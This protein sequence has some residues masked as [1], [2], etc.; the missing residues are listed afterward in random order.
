MKFCGEDIISVIV[1]VYN[2]EKYLKECVDSIRNQSYVNLEIILVDD[3]STD[4]SSELCDMFAEEDARIKVLH[5]KN[6]GLV[7]ARQE[8][9]K[10]ATGEYIVFVD[11]DDWI[12][13]DM[14]EKLYLL[15]R[16]YSTD[17]VISGII[18]EK[19]EGQKYDSN[20]LC[21]GYYDKEML[22]SNVYPH[23]MFDLEKRSYYIDPSLCNKL[24]RASLIKNCILM[25]DK[26]IFYLGEDAAVI[27]PCLLKADNIL[28]TKLCMYHHRIVPQE[29]VADY[30][31]EKI[32]ERLLILYKYLQSTYENMGMGDIMLPQ[33][34]GY[35]THMLGRTTY[36]AINFDFFTFLENY[37]IENS[38]VNPTAIN[39]FR[40]KF[41]FGQLQGY[42]R[43]I[44]YGAGKVGIEYYGQLKNNKYNVIL[45]VDKRGDDIAR[46]SGLPIKNIDNIK[47]KEFDIIILATK[48]KD[49][50]QEMRKDIESIGIESSKIRW[51]QPIE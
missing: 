44:L 22:K 6:G 20:I 48:K 24:F 26:E 40:Y 51:I 45:W 4:Q 9:T 39:M 23:M 50:S 46:I 35:F 5:K 30:K 47:G 18:R 10:L 21:E 1:I 43:I 41:P 13:V 2:V 32:F 14:Y 11:G 25:A 49:I 31:T 17:I 15:S 29:L 12:D 16:I 38:N 19:N 28:V 33:L 36:N 34:R 3:G 27:Y 42:K 37:F 7:S 8:G